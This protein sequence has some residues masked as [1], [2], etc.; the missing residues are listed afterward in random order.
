MNRRLAQTRACPRLFPAAAVLCQV[1]SKVTAWLTELGLFS[2]SVTANLVAF[3]EV[4][5][6]VDMGDL[7]E[8]DAEDHAALLAKVP[9]LKR[10]AF[11]VALNRVPAIAAKVRAPAQR[12]CDAMPCRLEPGPYPYP[13]S[14][15]YPYPSSSSSSSFYLGRVAGGAGSG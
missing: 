5:G 8:L 10:K 14:S 1:P 15:S 9:K 7:A 11:L 4:L 6:A 12:P 13:S 3:F 2:P